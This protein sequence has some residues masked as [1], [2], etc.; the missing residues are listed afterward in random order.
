MGEESVDARFS[1]ASADVTFGSGGGCIERVTCEGDKDKVS[2][3]AGKELGI[4][5]IGESRPLVLMYFGVRASDD[6]GGEM[7]CSTP[8]SKGKVWLRGR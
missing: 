5:A 7:Y 8:I 1:S 4:S 2:S 3:I 6:A